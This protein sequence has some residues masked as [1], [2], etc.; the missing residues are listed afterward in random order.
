MSNETVIAVVSGGADSTSYMAYY[1]KELDFDLKAITFDYGQK[2]KAELEALK[3]I[4]GELNI[5]LKVIDISFMKELWKGNQLTDENVKVEPGY[6]PSVVVP[7]RNGVM[8]SIALSYAYTVKA[9][10]VIYGS[11]KGDIGTWTNPAGVK[12][13]FY[14]D[15]SPEF[16]IA[17]ANAAKQGVFTFDPLVMIDSPGI[18]NMTKSDLLRAGHKALGNLLFETYSCYE[19]N[20][21]R[22]HCGTCESC[23]NRKN[24]FKTAGI[25]DK[26]VYLDL[27]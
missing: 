16:A 8:L 22:Y 14:P 25:N 12:E 5:P 24:A 11:H 1:Q 27:I 26:T 13:Y 4:C 21:D 7:L 19:N 17:F 23:N 9:K 6:A 20:K 3:Y 10:R 2:A 15:C 18:Q